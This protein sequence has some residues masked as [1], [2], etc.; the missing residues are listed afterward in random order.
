MGPGVENQSLVLTYA[1]D[2]MAIFLIPVANIILAYRLNNSSF[3]KVGYIFT[4]LL[5]IQPLRI[6]VRIQYVFDSFVSYLK[7]KT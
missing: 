3:I 5:L 6:S 7:W 2:S 1:S 4:R